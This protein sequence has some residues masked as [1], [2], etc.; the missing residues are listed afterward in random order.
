MQRSAR[1]TDDVGDQPA[2]ANPDLTEQDASSAARHQE[3]LASA[4]F[5]FERA[6]VAEQA[7][8][9][10]RGQLG[11]AQQQLACVISD[12]IQAIDQARAQASDLDDRLKTSNA[13]EREDLARSTQQATSLASAL[14]HIQGYVCLILRQRDQRHPNR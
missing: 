12:H 4:A 14:S 8:Y 10:L 3:A 6:R 9:Q 11:L 7:N 2:A 1:P 5:Q 13:L